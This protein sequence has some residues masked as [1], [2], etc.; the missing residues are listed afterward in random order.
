MRKRFET[1]LSL[2]QI[3]I[4]KV[5]IPL[6]SRDELPPTLAGLQ[7]IFSTP[8]IN[9]QVFELL[10]AKVIAGKKQTGRPGMDL[11]QILVLGV[12]RMALD[13]NYDRLEDMANHHSLLRQIMGLPAV[14]EEDSQFHYKTLSENVC[15][16]DE[17]LLEKINEIVVMHGRAAIKKNAVK[18]E[19]KTDS[20][21]L[22]TNVHF[23]TDVNLLWDA[24]RKSIELLSRLCDEVGV[25][26]WRKA[27]HWKTTIKGLMRQL[28]QAGRGGKNRQQRQQKS[29]REYIAK[30]TELSHKVRENIH[31][32][33]R[34]CHDPLQLIRLEQI[35]YFASMLDKHIDLLQRRVLKEETIAH[36]EKVFSLFE[37]HTE[38]I[39]KGKMRPPVELGHKILVTTDQHGLVLDYKVMEKSTDNQELVP[40][41]ERLLER[42]GV[43]A[44]Q[45]LSM[46][47]GFSDMTKLEALEKK[48]PM[49][50][51]PKKGR[52]N[53]VE[54]E[55][56]TSRQFKKLKHRHAAIES[57][58]NALEHHGL[59][60]CPDKGLS[61]YKRYV[62]LGVLAYNLHRIGRALLEKQRQASERT[63][64][65][66]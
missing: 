59:N 49:V 32:V 6:K 26:G 3:A 5:V 46:D 34:V 55:R 58:I 62:G 33:E 60:R 57:N 38:W 41:V 47:K 27:K 54:E 63:K 42:F 28:Q 43:D 37:E 13:C 14:S 40:L 50:V 39:A 44:V 11:W 25:E 22:E 36:E 10:E 48:I 1:Q 23:P 45:S 29:A 19:A 51:M 64:K 61:G 9:E 7:W 52:R 24:A 66:A 31:Q 21:V 4:E 16:V 8:Q 56:E 2:E 18:I 30:A 20:Y 65:A 53:Q 15:H 17:V 35:R 12:C